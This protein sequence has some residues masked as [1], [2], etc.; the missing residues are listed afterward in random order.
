MG[1][2]VESLFIVM[3]PCNHFINY[4]LDIEHLDDAVG[5][6]EC[7]VR[8]APSLAGGLGVHGDDGLFEAVSDVGDAVE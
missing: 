5:F 6:A 3:L 7:G 1:L 2:N 8:L 4:R